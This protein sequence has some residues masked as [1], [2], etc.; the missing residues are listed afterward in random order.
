MFESTPPQTLEALN[1]PHN[2]FDIRWTPLQPAAPSN[3][4]P[5]PTIKGSNSQACSLCPELSNPKPH[6]LIGN[7]SRSVLADTASEYQDERTLT[8]AVGVKGF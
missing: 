8:E 4:F 5:N 1:D 3:E 2:H 7:V 6:A